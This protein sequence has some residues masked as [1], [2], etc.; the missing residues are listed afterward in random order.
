MFPLWKPSIVKWAST[1][2]S[3]SV[4]VLLGCGGGRFRVRNRRNLVF[5]QQVARYFQGG[6]DAYPFSRSAKLRLLA[7]PRP[8]PNPVTV[9]GTGSRH[10]PAGMTW[11]AFSNLVRK[12][13]PIPSSRQG[14]AGPGGQGWHATPHK[15][16]RNRNR[17]PTNPKHS[18]GCVNCCGGIAYL[19]QESIAARSLPD[20]SN[21]PEVG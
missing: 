12:N 3:P 8:Q 15:F 2:H 1:Y 11:R 21:L 9:P 17:P 10:L 5:W 16:S 4:L 19:Q 7:R 14:L 13:S 6:V 20:Y 18:R